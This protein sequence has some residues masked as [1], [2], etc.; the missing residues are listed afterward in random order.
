MSSKVQKNKSAQKRAAKRVSRTKRK[1]GGPKHHGTYTPKLGG[2]FDIEKL[3]A[4][5]KEGKTMEALAAEARLRPGNQPLLSKQ[6]IQDLIDKTITHVMPAHAM[7][8][9]YTH[10]AD[11]DEIDRV[12]TDDEIKAIDEKTVRVME[13]V[14]SLMIA[15][16]Q[17]VMLEQLDDL[18]VSFM[19][20]TMT[21]M[22]QLIPE[23]MEKFEPFYP[24]INER[25]AGIDQNFSMAND[26]RSTHLKLHM[27]RME[28]IA[29]LYA[30]P[31]ATDVVAEP[32]PAEA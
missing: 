24:Q 18:V 28:R 22:V 16:H 30:T 17:G 21:L 27:Q 7:L 32:M 20:D 25:Y 29:P 14:N 26:H 2:D 10:L 5:V 12:L 3:R 9:I 4:W 1:V 8:D 19:D 15:F 31:A 13:T 6:Q 23:M 11:E